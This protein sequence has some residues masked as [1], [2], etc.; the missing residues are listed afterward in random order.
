MF[1]TAATPV[2]PTM[3]QQQVPGMSTTNTQGMSGHTPGLSQGIPGLSVNPMMQQQQ[4]QML[5]KL[6]QQGGMR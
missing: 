3:N 6:L 5:I 4:N 1:G 2:T